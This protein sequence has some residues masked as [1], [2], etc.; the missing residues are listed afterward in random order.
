MEIKKMALQD[1]L[2]TEKEMKEKLEM[3]EK[4]QVDLQEVSKLKTKPEEEYGQRP[5]ESK[6]QKKRAA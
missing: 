2:L 5:V 4:G 6:E 3:I 1:G